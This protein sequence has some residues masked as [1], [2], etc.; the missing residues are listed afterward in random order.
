LANE[1][2]VVAVNVIYL[3]LCLVNFLKSSSSGNSKRGM[4]QNYYGIIMVTKKMYFIL[5]NS[6]EFKI[7]LLNLIA[8][9]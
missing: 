2:Y 7:A 6:K 8:L 3:K 9:Y 1:I 5:E 4:L